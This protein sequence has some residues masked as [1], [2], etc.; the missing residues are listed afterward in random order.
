MATKRN[1][2]PVNSGNQLKNAGALDSAAVSLLLGGDAKSFVKKFHPNADEA[3]LDF[4]AD[5]FSFFQIER[6]ED[7]YFRIQNFLSD[8]NLNPTG[9]ERLDYFIQVVLN[10]MARSAL[11]N[12]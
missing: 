4:Y 10:V 1:R 8:N 9:D 7:T 5:V 6:R 12:K 3:S 11:N 2:K